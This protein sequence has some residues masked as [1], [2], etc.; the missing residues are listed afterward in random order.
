MSVFYGQV[1]GQA[2]TTASR[3]GSYNSGIR[4]SAQSWDGSLITKMYYSGGDDLMVEIE[5][6]DGSS[7]YGITVY[8][9]KFDDFVN[10]MLKRA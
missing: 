4:V 10:E 6:S 1:S 7:M 9:G 5:V 3:R 8:S 2:E